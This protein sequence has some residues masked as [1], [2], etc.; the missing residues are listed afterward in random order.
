[1][2]APTTR[3]S[4]RFGLAPLCTEFYGPF[5]AK[6]PDELLIIVLAWLP[7]CDISSVSAV[8]R[9]WCVFL[10]PPHPTLDEHMDSGYSHTDNPPLFPLAHPTAG[11]YHRSAWGYGVV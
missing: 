4:L 7:A 2:K 10:T 3:P 1:M 9:G 6:L 11:I 5:A 8:S